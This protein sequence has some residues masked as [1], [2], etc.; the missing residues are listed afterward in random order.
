MNCSSES[1][2]FYSVGIGPGDPKLMTLKAVETIERCDIIAV[3]NS[4]SDENI[5][6]KI[7]KAYIDGKRIVAAYM[8]MTRD[9]AVLE[10]NHSKAAGELAELLSQGH[11]IAFLTLGDPSIYSTAMYIHKR[12]KSLGFQTEIIAGVPSFC[13]AAASL[14]ITL[15]E[16]AEAL[17][18]IPAS[19]PNTDAALALRGNKILMKSGK[20][21]AAVK[22]KLQGKNAMMV[23]RASMADEKVYYTLEEVDES[24]SYF[25][26]VV[27]KE[28]L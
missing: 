16:G 10:E 22:D 11:S 13:A 8:P 17:H 7:A 25:S 18:I 14:D 2:K 27:I 5:A 21:I 23:E 24:A 12:I 19:Y 6:L 20:S 4:G 9:L 3:P 26:V 1:G 28:E 15:C